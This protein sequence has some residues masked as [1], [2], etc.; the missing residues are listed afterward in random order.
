M[1]TTISNENKILEIDDDVR[2]VTSCIYVMRSI[3][4]RFHN[5]VTSDLKLLVGSAP[6]FDR[7]RRYYAY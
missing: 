5:I 4:E 1:C 6:G 7:R 3:K 2:S